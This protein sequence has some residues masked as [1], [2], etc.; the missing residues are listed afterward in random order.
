M[1]LMFL[2]MHIYKLWSC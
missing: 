2:F 1:H